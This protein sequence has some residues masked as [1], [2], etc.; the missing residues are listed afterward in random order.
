MSNFLAAMLA[1]LRPELVQLV[2]E[3]VASA[4][5]EEGSRHYPEMVSVDVASEITSYS[6]NSLYQM[7]SKGQ[8]P[9]A[10]KVG[11]K[12]LFNADALRSWVSSGKTAK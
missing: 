5:R 2:Q 1:E 9:G 8:V 7:H 4:L 6:K 3:A 11:G 10:K 12:L